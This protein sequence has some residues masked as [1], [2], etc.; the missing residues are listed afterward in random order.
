MYALVKFRGKV[1]LRLLMRGGSVYRWGRVIVMWETRQ[2]AFPQILIP[3]MKALAAYGTCAESNPKIRVT[4]NG[5][6]N[7]HVA[8]LTLEEGITTFG[9]L[10]R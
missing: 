2:Q 10:L 6:R 5:F 4:I 3:Q 7:N 1:S 9:D 8:R